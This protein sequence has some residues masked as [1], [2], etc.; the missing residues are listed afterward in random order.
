MFGCQADPRRHF[1]AGLWMSASGTFE[2]CPAILRMSVHRRRPEVA[3][4]RSDRRE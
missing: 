1:C 3:V 2:T 4:D